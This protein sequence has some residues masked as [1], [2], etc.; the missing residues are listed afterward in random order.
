MLSEVPASIHVLHLSGSIDPTNG[1][2]KA[3]GPG[4]L[5]EK[6]QVVACLPE[7]K[8][9]MP[10]VDLLRAVKEISSNQQRFGAVDCATTLTHPID[11]T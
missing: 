3:K 1:M 5:L 9:H 10:V 4:L 8:I 2:M 6:G 11:L 7:L